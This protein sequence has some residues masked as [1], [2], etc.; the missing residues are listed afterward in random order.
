MSPDQSRDDTYNNKKV[1]VR[2]KFKGEDNEYRKWMTL[3]QYRN[4][5]LV[6]II[7]YCEIIPEGEKKN[8]E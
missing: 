1:L 7:E 3:F 5:K 2:F 6:N 8:H 4:L